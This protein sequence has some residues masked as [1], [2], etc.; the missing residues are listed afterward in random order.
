MLI[1][2]TQEWSRSQLELFVLDEADVSEQY[3]GWLNDSRINQYLESRGVVHTLESTREFVSQARVNASTLFLGIRWGASSESRRH[4]GNIKIEINRRHGLGEIGIMIG[5]SQVWG[6]GVAR[7]SIDMLCTIAAQ[8]LSIRKA[9]AGCY[10]S[11]LGSKNAFVRAGFEIEGCRRGHFL[12]D[13][14]PE[15]LILM[16]RWLA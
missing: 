4:V 7:N 6:R 2:P 14:Q 9:T 16:A 10:A 3:V 8:Q 12:L 1:T 5:D 11:N 13:G 15:D